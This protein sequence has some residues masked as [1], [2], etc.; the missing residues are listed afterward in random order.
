MKT[1]FVGHSVLACMLV[2]TYVVISL[3]ACKN[4]KSGKTENGDAMCSVVLKVT[5]GKIQARPEI[6]GKVKKNSIIVFT[7]TPDNSQTHQVDKWSIT[8][9]EV[10]EGGKQGHSR[11]KVKI[12][13]DATISVSFT[14]I[15][16]TVTMEASEEGTIT[17][18]PSI[19]DGK[20]AKDTA[21]TFTATPKTP[22]SHEVDKWTITGGF[23]Q[24]G[25]EDGDA[26]ARVKITADTT[27]RVTFKER[28]KFTVT[29]NPCQNGS[30]TSDVDISNP[31]YKDTIIT[32]TAIPTD[33]NVHEVD[34]W[35]IDGGESGVKVIE[36]ART[37][38]KIAKVQIIANTTVTATFAS[39]SYFDAETGKGCVAGIPFVM[40]HIDA[41]TDVDIGHEDQPD[42]KP[43]KVS[44]SAYMIGETEVTRELFKQ[45]VGRDVSLFTNKPHGNEVQ[46]KRPVEMVTWY[47]AIFFCNKLSLKVGLEPCYTVT[48]D[49]KP[50]DFATFDFEKIP[51]FTDADWEAC[52][53]DMS[54]NGFRLPTEAE[55]EWA[56]LGGNKFK[57]CNTDDPKEVK[58][59]AWFGEN[60]QID[61]NP[62]NLG[63]HQVA[64]D[65]VSGID[66]KNGYGLY[67]MGGNVFEWCQDWYAD[68]TPEGGK[69]PTGPA[70]GKEKV[71]RGGSYQFDVNT[72][73][74][75]YRDTGKTIDKNSGIGLRI[76]C[77]K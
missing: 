61:G 41:V 66:S 19:V 77:R 50:L 3:G 22:T 23:L 56:A 48:V 2:L 21:I 1:R 67:D 35:D 73:P 16:F 6:S 30:V 24:T 51:Q 74:C 53:V 5:G 11:A 42:N 17:A 37:G 45:V 32:F 39:K 57:F 58:K 13:G 29:V 4:N 38:S 7:A 46:G 59:Y 54:K 8:G 63:T 71:Y 26:S 15:L 9:A 76:V 55:W 14:E 28:P 64:I 52:T 20:V 25:G 27:V 69:D 31:V 75:S 12:I 44:L 43:H 60:S 33:S 18:T 68:T 72:L 65:K 47:R 70:T 34:D 62:K 36:G 40:K 10:L 49:G